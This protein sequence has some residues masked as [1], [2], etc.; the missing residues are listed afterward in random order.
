MLGTFIT[1]F[2]IPETK[3][4]SLLAADNDE[5]EGEA[6]K[7]L[8]PRGKNDKII[9]VFDKISRRVVIIIICDALTLPNSKVNLV[10]FTK[11]DTSNSNLKSIFRFLHSPC[12]LLEFSFEILLNSFR[13]AI[14]NFVF[15]RRV[16]SQQ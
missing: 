14:F 7:M 3:G 9:Q 4:K 2:F 13:L 11:S 10:I 6:C 8:E 15:V 16:E 5:A 1:I 12:D